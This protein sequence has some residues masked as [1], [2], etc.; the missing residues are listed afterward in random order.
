[1]AITRSQIARQLLAEG[2]VSLDDAKMMAPEGEFLAY[3]NPKEA[4][5]LK[6]AGGSGIMTPMGIP[7]FVEYGGAE[8]TAG[9][10][11][12]QDQVDS[13]SGGDSD[14]IQDQIQS[15]LAPKTPVRDIVTSGLDTIARF[16]IPGYGRVRS[17]MDISNFISRNTQPKVTNLVD[18]VALT[19][20]RTP[21]V[22]PEGD[23]DTQIAQPVMPMMPL[24]PKLPSD[25]EAE[26]SDIAKFTQRFS[27]P[28]RFRLAD[29]GDVHDDT[30]GEKVGPGTRKSKKL[31]LYKM[32]KIDKPRKRK[33]LEAAEGGEVTVK[34]AEK[35]A[36][37][38]EFLAY[39]N[40]DDDTGD[41]NIVKPMMPMVPKLPTDIEPEKSDYAEFVQRFTLPERFRLAE[42]GEP[43]Q[44]YGLGKLVKKV[45]GAVK[46]VAKSPIG[47]AAITGAVLFGIPGM[48][49]AGG[50]GGGLLGRASFG[51]AAP[52]VFGL[53]GI[54]NLFAGKALGVDKF[55]NI[56]KGQSPFSKLLSKIPGG[57]LTAGLVG[58]SLAA[59]LL[60][61]KQEQESISQRIADN[62]GIDVEKIRK[63]VQEAYASGDTKSLRTKYPFLI[64]ESAAAKAEGGR[65]GF[66][67]GGTYEDFEKFMMKRQ[68]SM[69]ERQKEELRKQFEMYMK[70]KDPT[71]EA[72]VGGKIEDKKEKEGIMMASNIENESILENLFEKYLDMGLSP[73][74]AEKAARDEFDRMSK[75]Q[76][77]QRTTAAIGGVINEEDEM[78][79]MGG[80]EMDLR[81][82]GFV[83]LGEYEKKDDVPARLSKNEFVFTADAVRAAGG[84]SV[85]RGAD[86]MYKTMKQLENKVV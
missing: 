10:S 19:G 77:V 79:D 13:F 2:G 76:G 11:A 7:S 32:P 22:T 80:N 55:D 36:P 18:E 72:A 20:G 16:T 57:G 54:Q 31:K 17:A 28:E 26:Q 69:S 14:P 51:G 8:A 73:K 67:N 27:L 82:G 81:G 65:I 48:G 63:E 70:S 1:M 62:T 60:G 40:D 49:A 52:G 41:N 21:T 61:S 47:K 78:L 59:G 30:D 5:M 39:I 84:G 12:S 53:G 86:L 4:N 44:A 50:L 25:I 3:I 83:P 43:R 24:V 15:R 33:V 66:E 34:D 64:T 42:G 37:K 75:K 23:S 46:K 74:E 6:Q 9:A 35:L 56:I 29:G 85:D 38:G 58:T 68:E 45:T 71:V